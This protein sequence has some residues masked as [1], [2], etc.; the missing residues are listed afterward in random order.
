MLGP[1]SLYSCLE[2]QFCWKVDVDNNIEPPI[3]T[4]HV[5]S[6]GAMIFTFKLDGASAEISLLMRS[7]KPLNMVVPPDRTM[8][9]YMSLR[10]SI[11]HFII[12][13]YT[14]SCTPSGSMPSNDG[15][16]SAS[17]QRKLS[18]IHI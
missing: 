12:E 7:A 15:L 16:K 6:G 18:L 17:T 5:R 11:S 14:S 8:F 13:L 9:E 10:R 4:E 3:H 1:D 2:I